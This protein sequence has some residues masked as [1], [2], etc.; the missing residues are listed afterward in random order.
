MGASLYTPVGPK[1]S[2]EEGNTGPNGEAKAI[3]YKDPTNAKRAKD[4]LYNLFLEGKITHNSRIEELEAKLQE[5]MNANARL[6]TRL[7]LLDGG[8]TDANDLRR[9]NSPRV[10][11]SRQLSSVASSH[12]IEGRRGSSLRIKEPINEPINELIDRP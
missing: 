5:C 10:S 6:R 9:G 1:S 12:R 8:N 7:Q 4:E 2:H 11:G 3:D